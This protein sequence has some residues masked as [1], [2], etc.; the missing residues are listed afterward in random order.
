MKTEIERKFLV[1][2]DPWSGATPRSYLYQGYLSSTLQSVVRVRADDLHLK[3][4]IT[5]KGPT[6]GFTRMEYEYEIPWQDSTVLRTVCKHAIIKTRYLITFQDRTWHV[7][8]FHGDNQGL[9]TA[10]LELADEAEVW[11]PPSWLGAE[12]SHDPRYF[13]NNLA[14]TPWTTWSGWVMRM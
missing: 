5:I 8:E 2:Y 12:V 10:E 11:E 13:N 3:A 1:K 6:L 14:R 4:W 9:V 7:D